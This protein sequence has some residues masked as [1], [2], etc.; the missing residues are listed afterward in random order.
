MSE[1]YY[2]LFIIVVVCHCFGELPRPNEQMQ[3]ISY[4]T[5]KQFHSVSSLSHYNLGIPIQNEICLFPHMPWH[6]I[7]L[8][9]VRFCYSFRFLCLEIRT[10][11]REKNNSNQ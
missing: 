8:V 11:P 7:H 2:G 6:F 9:C 4:S 3:P 5:D 1:Q 10:E